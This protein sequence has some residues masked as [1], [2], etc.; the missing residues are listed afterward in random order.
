[1]LWK[2]YP[3]DELTE[4]LNW[5][6]E[7]RGKIVYMYEGDNRVVGWNG[8]KLLRFQRLDEK[9]ENNPLDFMPQEDYASKRIQ[10]IL[11]KIDERR[12]NK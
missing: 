2:E 10:E 5:I 8:K 7:K 9:D 1:M 3:Y 11:R 4:V 6:N 12:S